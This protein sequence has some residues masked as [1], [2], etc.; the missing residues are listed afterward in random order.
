MERDNE[1]KSGHRLGHLLLAADTYSRYRISLE[2][3]WSL[4]HDNTHCP[5]LG[6]DVP[7]KRERKRET[8]LAVKIKKTKT[9]QLPA[10]H[11]STSEVIIVNHIPGRPVCY[12]DLRP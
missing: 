5:L 1:A 7:K 12:H 8:S 3:Q 2:L 10:R 9:E 11:L 4:A 6:Q